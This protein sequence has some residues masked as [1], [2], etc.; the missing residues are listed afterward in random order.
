MQDRFTRLL[1]ACERLARDEAAALARRNIESLRRAQQLK[2]EMVAGL[3]TEA[4]NV[5]LD[6]EVRARLAQLLKATRENS[7]YLANLKAATGERLRK[8]RISSNRL[9]TLQAAYNP[10]GM[11]GEQAFY[12]HG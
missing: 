8:L 9:H 10:G 4:G 5:P 1:A 7:V 3:A 12:A 6:A 11:P 2:A